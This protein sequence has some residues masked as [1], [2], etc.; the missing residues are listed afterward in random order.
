M[1]TTVG[2]IDAFYSESPSRNTTPTNCIGRST[3]LT[4]PSTASSS[5]P[6]NSHNHSHHTSASGSNVGLSALARSISHPVPSGTHHP[7]RAFRTLSRHNDTPTLS[8]P[9]SSSTTALG[10]GGILRRF[11]FAG[12]SSSESTRSRSSSYNGNPPVISAPIPTVPSAP[13]VASPPL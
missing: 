12:S 1:N 13:T 3:T 8:R 4:P 7:L 9:G 5:P 10:F 6:P 11:G 2:P